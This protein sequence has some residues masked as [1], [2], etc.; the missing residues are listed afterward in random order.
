M[1]AAAPRKKT[2]PRAIKTAPPGDEEDLADFIDLD[3]QSEEEKGEFEETAPLFRIH[4]EI[5]AARV[6]FSAGETI[7]F[8]ELWRDNGLD[9]A[10]AYAMTQA[11]GADGYQAFL[12]YP[13]MSKENAGKIIDQVVNRINPPV[14]DPKSKKA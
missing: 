12:N 8:A 6:V 14:I 11:L 9:K 10:C 4:G 13:Y 3:A 5:Y 7:R 2:T 1:A